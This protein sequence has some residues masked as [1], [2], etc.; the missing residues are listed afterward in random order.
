MNGKSSG[1]RPVTR[2]QALRALGGASLVS[3][4]GCS[5]DGSGAGETTGTS[6]GSTTPTGGHRPEPTDTAT[7]TPTEDVDVEGLETE[8]TDRSF[9]GRLFDTHAHWAG[10]RDAG[11][12]PLDPET[13]GTRMNEN[14]VGASVLFTSSVEADQEYPAVLEQLS[15]T[16]VDYLP[17]LQPQSRSHLI[18]GGVTDVYKDHPAAFVGIGEI[19]L[20]GGPMQG[21][22]LTAEPWP[23][24][25]AFSADEEVPLMI[26]PTQAQE[27]GLE[28]MLSDH[29]GATVMAHGGE[30]NLAQEKLVSLLEDHG[31]L[32]WTLDAGS[33]LNG[34]VLTASDASD[35]A[36]RYDERKGEF[37]QLVEQV[38]PPLM[39]AAPN[40]VMW[41]T[42]VA[43]NWNTD[44]AV[45]SRIM[46]WTQTAIESLPP[47]RR[48]KYAYENAKRLFGL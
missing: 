29:P 34:L 21:T 28:T 16:A 8:L 13:F 9:E 36:S 11:H 5:N 27:T 35:F 4:A 20:Y 44:P 19:I 43:T 14:G 47:D 39:D 23:E 25:F 12:V 45:Y 18:D 42:D 15:T 1:R 24:L 3:L 6:T 32:Y 46:D 38:L 30:F 33:M 41:G 26:H 17:F 37:D 48:D 40:R 7:E 2:R 31:N 22:S 10:A